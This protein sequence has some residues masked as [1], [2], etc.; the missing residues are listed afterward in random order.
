MMVK[1]RTDNK[2]FV[3]TREV[4]QTSDVKEPISKV[5]NQEFENF[6]EQK[7]MHLVKLIY[8]IKEQELESIFDTLNISTSTEI[9]ERLTTPALE[10]VV[11][12]Q[13]SV[14]QQLVKAIDEKPS[15]KTDRRKYRP[16]HKKDR[17]A[18]NVTKERKSIAPDNDP[19]VKIWSGI[20]KRFKAPGMQ[21]VGTSNISGID[22]QTALQLLYQIYKSKNNHGSHNVTK[23]P[24]TA[25]SK[26]VTEILI[27]NLLKNPA[28]LQQLLSRNLNKNEETSGFLTPAMLQLL[29][30]SVLKTA[31][32]VEKNEVLDKGSE[33]KALFKENQNLD[34][35]LSKIFDG[36]S[37]AMS[38]VNSEKV[39]QF[40][41]DSPTTEGSMP[42]ED[43]KKVNPE[44]LKQILLQL[45]KNSSLVRR[46]NINKRK[47][48]DSFLKSNQII[49]RSPRLTTVETTR[50]ATSLVSSEVS[51][52]SEDSSIS[53]QESNIRDSTT[54][55]TDVEDEDEDEDES[56]TNS[57][58]LT[59]SSITSTPETDETEDDDGDSATGERDD[60]FKSEI[61]TEND[62]TL[63]TEQ[64]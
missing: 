64:S 15:R 41:K 18:Q 53:D 10:D 22:L 30:T 50:N 62:T 58:V 16:S 19:D 14:I 32:K 45:L 54:E 25:S 35:K 49:A 13:S 4:S 44:K 39:S 12:M 21:S 31:D 26:P 63:P 40:G 29:A 7:G 56:T 27:K 9:G 17:N 8:R 2:R 60:P 34:G 52:H 5:T 1:K 37:K 28:F 59:K 47:A 42:R 46:S 57:Y 6:Y 38:P 48:R 43:D 11:K 3:G 23:I 36:K 51:S 55:D 33:E 20:E 24:T 61:L